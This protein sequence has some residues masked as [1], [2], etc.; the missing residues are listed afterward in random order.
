MLK[1][2]NSFHSQFS[3]KLINIS[4]IAGFFSLHFSLPHI[5]FC[6]SS[7]FSR[8]SRLSFCLTF[9]FYFLDKNFP[10]THRHRGG[11]VLYIRFL[12]LLDDMRMEKA[13]IACFFACFW[14]MRR[15][16]YLSIFRGENKSTGRAAES[17][18]RRRN[19]CEFFIAALLLSLN[20]SQCEMKES[21]DHWDEIRFFALLGNRWNATNKNPMMYVNLW[22]RLTCCCY[23][24]Y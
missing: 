9:A 11:I 10:C 21:T 13:E 2:E 17:E 16:I 8:F 24:L 6:F 20:R 5:I 23:Q 15:W 1:A 18:L 19:F 4:P 12:L 3:N 14:G 7:F 22:K